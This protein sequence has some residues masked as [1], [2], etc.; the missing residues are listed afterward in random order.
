MEIIN[1]D[2]FGSAK[3]DDP[4]V[5]KNELEQMVSGD[6]VPFIAHGTEMMQPQKCGFPKISIPFWGCVGWLGRV[7]SHYFHHLSNLSARCQVCKGW[8]QVEILR[9]MLLGSARNG[10]SCWIDVSIEMERY[11]DKDPN[12][13]I[14]RTPSHTFLEPS[15]CM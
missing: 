8:L 2:C 12:M 15:L 9:L 3:T 11:I 13:D 1:S 5:M 6:G 4:P 7:N 10:A 14:A